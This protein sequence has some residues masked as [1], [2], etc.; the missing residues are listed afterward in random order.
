MVMGFFCSSNGVDDSAKYMAVIIPRNS[1]IPVEKSRQFF[2]TFDNQTSA[3][4]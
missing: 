2:T 1:L 3:L 4:V